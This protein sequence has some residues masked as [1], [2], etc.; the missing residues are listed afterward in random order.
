MRQ[1]SAVVQGLSRSLRQYYSTEPSIVRLWLHE[2]ERVLSI[3]PRQWN[4]EIY[5]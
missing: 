1:T 3:V 5:K 4:L 2:T